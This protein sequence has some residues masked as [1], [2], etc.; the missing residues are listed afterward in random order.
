MEVAAALALHHFLPGT[1]SKKQRAQGA[2]NDV[3]NPPT[4]HQYHTSHL[5]GKQAL[6]FTEDVRYGFKR[7]QRSR[8]LNTLWLKVSE[9]PPL[10][11]CQCWQLLLIESKRSSLKLCF[12]W[13][14]A[15]N[16]T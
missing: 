3:L 5:R 7:L 13:F 16:T 1:C 9:V 12:L 15:P 6:T 10:T 2:E 8:G 14:V 4:L 11:P